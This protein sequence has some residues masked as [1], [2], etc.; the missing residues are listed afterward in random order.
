MNA[1]CV[2][3]FLKQTDKLLLKH[4]VPEHYTKDIILRF[5]RFIEKHRDED[6]S[7]PE[8]ACFLHRM[9]K[10]AVR[11]QDLYKQEKEYYNNLLLSHEK[12]IRKSIY[13]SDDPFQSALR[14]AVAGN[15]IDF[16]PPGSFDVHET[17]SAALSK[18][19]AV[20]HTEQLRVALQKA[21][22]VL[23]LAD[24]AGEIV[25]DKIF[26]DIINHPGLFFAVRGGNVIN[27]VTLEDARYV[28]VNKIARV[29]SNGYDAPSTLLNRCSPGFVSIFNDADIIISK[30]QGNL[31]GLIQN[32]GKR[33]FF[34][35]M[36][37]C[38]VI[39]ELTGVN[40]GDVVILDNRYLL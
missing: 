37:K 31:E 17:L 15:I 22:K 12:D 35:L 40:K 6:I 33:I 29:I 11:T 10:K 38:E 27:D 3:C 8:C 25:M 1:G 32:T 34:L 18:E 26:I 16:G 9:I 30:G 21:S 4:N 2:D 13:A 5:T 20:N 14:Y 36:V 24:N 39:A 7:S 19:P 23:Y 28:G